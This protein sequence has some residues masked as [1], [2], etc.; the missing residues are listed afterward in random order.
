M[1]ELES[2]LGV[3]Y[4]LDKMDMVHVNSFGGAMENWGLIMYEFDYLLYN[5]S[6]PDPDDDRGNIFLQNKIIMD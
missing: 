5:P 6:L 4:T 1:S 2:L 3:A